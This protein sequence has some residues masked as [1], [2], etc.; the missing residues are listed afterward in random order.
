MYVMF[1]V[2]WAFDKQYKNTATRIIQNN[3]ILDIAHVTKFANH[4][5]SKLALSFFIGSTTF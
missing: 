3:T 5:I 4:R 2:N 1:V